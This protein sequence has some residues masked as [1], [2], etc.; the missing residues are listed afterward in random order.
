M[1]LSLPCTTHAAQSMHAPCVDLSLSAVLHSMC[2]HA[3]LAG[4]LLIMNYDRKQSVRAHLCTVSSHHSLIDPLSPLLPSFGST[5]APCKA[6]E[7][8][9]LQS[10]LQQNARLMRNFDVSALLALPSCSPHVLTRWMRLCPSM[11]CAFSF[12][13]RH[14]LSTIMRNLDRFA[15]SATTRRDSDTLSH[16]EHGSVNVQRFL[17]DASPPPVSSNTL[18][19]SL[20]VS[21]R[22]AAQCQGEVWCGDGVVVFCAPRV[23]VFALQPTFIRE[24]KLKIMK[25]VVSDDEGALYYCIPSRNPISWVLRS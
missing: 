6:Y 24:S 20:S 23:V 10:A 4:K 21:P 9:Q 12:S 13:R 2:T 1:E 18:S 14:S 5:D 11:L 25:V 19:V 16:P 8:P 15:D 3:L 17:P 7:L 22:R